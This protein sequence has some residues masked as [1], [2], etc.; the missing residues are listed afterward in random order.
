MKGS[1]IQVMSLDFYFLII[2][3]LWF[4]LLLKGRRKM[5]VG[6]YVPEFITPKYFLYDLDQGFPQV[7]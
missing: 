1:H 4:N 5:V 6:D 3:R 7:L 2:Y